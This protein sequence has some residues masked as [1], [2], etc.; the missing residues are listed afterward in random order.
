MKLKTGFFVSFE[1]GEGVGKSTLM[2]AL[3]ERL[4]EDG[5]EVVCSKEPGGTPVGVQLRQFMLDHAQTFSDIQTELLLFL[6][7]RLEHISSVLKPALAAG[8]IVLCDRYMDST[9]AYQVGG[10][11]LDSAQ[12][13]YLNEL[14]TLRP[15][16]TLLLDL[17]PEQGLKR[18]AKRSLPDRFEREALAFHQ[19]V[20]AK[21]LSL[22]EAHPDRMRLIDVCGKQPEQ[23]LEE[24]YICVKT[25]LEEVCHA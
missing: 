1:G 3:A 2:P 8:K 16:L 24:A 15:Q 14:V 12:V 18:A 9:L 22:F 5:F 19:R 10:R 13:T 25:R 7:D 20:R 23:V 4:K 21:Y 17:P 6:A 11:Q